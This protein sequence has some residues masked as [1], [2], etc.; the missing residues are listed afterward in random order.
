MPE[1][2][3]RSRMV[4]I[5]GGMGPA[6]TVDFY[7][8]LI[9]ATPARRDQEH[10]R[11]VIWADPTVPDRFEALVKGKGDPTPWLIEG[12]RHLIE[13][14]A[15]ILVVPCNT[16]H[17]YM[18]SIVED[19]DIEFISI[20]DTAIEAANQ[21]AQGGRVG[22]LATDGALASELYQ[23]ALQTAGL[24]LILPSLT[25]QQTLM[26]TIYSIKAGGGGQEER[27]QI[28]ALLGQLRAAG[29]S[30][31]IAGCTDISVLLAD[32]NVD[33]DVIDP[34]HVLALK[35]VERALRGN[36]H[37]GRCVSSSPRGTIPARR[38]S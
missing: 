21:S 25:S 34:A 17:A 3:G 22:L 27:T 2:D 5:L 35:T 8:K 6:A 33:L 28:I 9:R 15:D 38:N 26:R 20:I 24:E 19:Q 29:A 36:D 7:T 31:V 1:R 14:G 18:P 4:G 37:A 16:I 13:C 23:S 10:L 11:T 12:V 32:L 30:T